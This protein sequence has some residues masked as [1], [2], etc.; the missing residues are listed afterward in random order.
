[1]L[2]RM[3]YSCGD[4][5]TVH[6]RGGRCWVWATTALR[7]SAK[8]RPGHRWTEVTMQPETSMVDQ[9]NIDTTHGPQTLRRWMPF[10]GAANMRS[11]RRS[12]SGQRDTLGFRGCG[13]LRHFHA[14]QSTT[15]D[16]LWW[17][18]LS[19]CN[20]PESLAAQDYAACKHHADIVCC[21]VLDVLTNEPRVLTARHRPQNQLQASGVAFRSRFESCRCSA[22]VQ[23]GEH[24]HQRHTES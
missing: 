24:V 13:F 4:M 11:N 3:R 18:E 16:Y 22:A 2:A 15:S 14:G 9:C 19:M 5:G 7:R 1:V 17:R 12:L 20:S 23:G 6:Q 8:F 21:A 10:G